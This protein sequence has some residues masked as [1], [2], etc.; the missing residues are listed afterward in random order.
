LSFDPIEEDTFVHKKE[1]YQKVLYVYAK[2]VKNRGLQLLS[3]GNSE[4]GKKVIIHANNILD[5]LCLDE[6][7]EKVINSE[8]IFM[9]DQKYFKLIQS[10]S[11]ERLFLIVDEKLQHFNY[12]VR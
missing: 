7:F 4:V 6:F 8:H 9:Q 5:A 3:E 2:S 12:L 1:I 10:S 11:V